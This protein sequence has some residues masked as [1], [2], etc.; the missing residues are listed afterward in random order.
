MTLPQEPDIICVQISTNRLAP[1]KILVG[2]RTHDG[3]KWKVIFA[4]HSDSPIS[5]IGEK[6][7][8][9]PLSEPMFPGGDA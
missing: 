7:R 2:M 8:M 5:I 9:I 3:E 4:L 1:G 6:D